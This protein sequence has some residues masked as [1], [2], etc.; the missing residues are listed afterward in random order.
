MP[1]DF[2]EG[3]RESAD[4]RMGHVI[5][6]VLS[7]GMIF[8]SSVIEPFYQ[9]EVTPADYL[10]GLICIAYGFGLTIVCRAY[11]GEFWTPYVE[12]KEY[13]EIVSQGP[14]AVVRHP[15]YTGLIIAMLGTVV[16]VATPIAFLGFLTFVWSF[17][18]KLNHEEDTFKWSSF[19]HR[20]EFYKEDVPWK[21][22][23]GIY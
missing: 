16:L 6:L 22:F 12:I 19:K 18:I 10:A 1:I 21:L 3:A 17:T 8:S 15:I 4:R 5:P 7:C 14:Y 9:W 23:P 20:Y 11:L 2:S 13:H